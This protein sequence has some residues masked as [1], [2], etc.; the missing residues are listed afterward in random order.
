MSGV[1]KIYMQ[2]FLDEFAKTIT[3]DIIMVMDN[4]GWHKGLDV[5]KNIQIIYLPPYSPEL[6]PVERLWLHIKN[7]TLKNKVYYQLQDLEDVVYCFLKQMNSNVIK[8]VCS[9]SYVRL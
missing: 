5:P 1:D 3:D 6:N 8:S 9:C 7:H 4:A 2:V